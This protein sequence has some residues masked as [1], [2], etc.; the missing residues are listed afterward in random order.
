MTQVPWR[1]SVK[2]HPEEAIGSLVIRLAPKGLL[3]PGEFLKYHFNRDDRLPPVDLAT[4][5]EALK[6]LALIGSFDV[7]E[8]YRAAWKT[9]GLTIEFL[10]R[11][12][13]RE[14]F[15]PQDRRLAP[16]VLRADGDDPWIRNE[17]QIRALP[18]DLETGEIVIERCVNC[19]ELLT[20]AFII[21]FVC[22]G[23]VATIS[24]GLGRVMLPK[25]F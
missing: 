6:E 25:T 7:E 16:G 24:A 4:D 13:P 12:L 2:H 10:G 5:P 18:C 9:I 11:K 19:G 17:W 3:T 1:S 14:W 21:A 22:A 8:L 15:S 20:W 23:S